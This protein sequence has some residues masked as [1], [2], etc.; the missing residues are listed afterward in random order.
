VEN[1]DRLLEVA[2][3]ARNFAKSPSEILGIKNEVAALDFD[4][5]C[6]YRLLVFDNERQVGTAK[7]IAYEAAKAIL[8]TKEESAAGESG[9]GETW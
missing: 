6:S 1:P 3:M 4:R 5:A 2:L 8:G 7:L 9:Y